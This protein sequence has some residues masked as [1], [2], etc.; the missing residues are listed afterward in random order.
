MIWSASSGYFALT[1]RASRFWR[2]AASAF[3]L[4]GLIGASMGHQEMTQPL[5]M[6]CNSASSQDIRPNRS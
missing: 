4:S 1:L 3:W 6:T 2:T 5:P